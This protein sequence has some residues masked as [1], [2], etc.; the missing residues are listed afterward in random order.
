[1]RPLKHCRLLPAPTLTVLRGLGYNKAPYKCPVC[2]SSII[3]PP[4]P[5]YALNKLTAS[6]SESVT[7]TFGGLFDNE[8]IQGLEDWSCYF[9]ES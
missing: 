5:I 6:I 9:D 8:C 1:M 7:H 3:Y 4:S 2:C